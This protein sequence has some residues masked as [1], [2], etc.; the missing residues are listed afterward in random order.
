MTEL[1]ASPVPTRTPHGLRVLVVDDCPE[2][3]VSVKGALERAGLT[4][5]GEAADGVQ[6]LA[7]AAEQRPDVILMDLRMPRMDGIVATRALRALQPGTPVLLWTGDG[8][9]QLDGAVREAGAYAGLSKGV[10][11]TEL[12]ATL[13]RI[14]ACA[15]TEPD[16]R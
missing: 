11:L 1:Y 15:A 7:Q 4:V 9:V 2:L 8:D 5:V 6:A 13:R 14:C 12:V 16:P 3:R 10:R